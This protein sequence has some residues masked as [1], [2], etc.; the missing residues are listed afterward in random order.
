MKKLL[1]MILSAALV[2]TAAVPAYAAESESKQL[3]TVIKA[4][5]S[6]ITVA[7]DAS[8]SY[9][10]Y[11]TQNGDETTRLW[12]LTWEKDKEHV[13]VSALSDGKI[14]SYYHYKDDQEENKGLTSLSREQ[15]QK[16]AEAFLQKALPAGISVAALQLHDSRVSD[17]TTD[18]TYYLTKSGT[19]GTLL[20][21]NITF[22]VT[23]DR[24]EKAV[25][26]YYT[27][28][29]LQ[30]LTATLP[31]DS[32]LI[33]KAKAENA[34]LENDGLKLAYIPVSDYSKKQV[35]AFVGYV[36]DDDGFL[37]DAKTGEVIN[38]RQYYYR[39]YDK[40]GMGGGMA[41][42]SSNV[43]LSPAEQ[44]EVG[45]MKDLMS[46]DEAM[47]ILK[48]KVPAMSKAGKLTGSSFSSDYFAPTIYYWDISFENGS[49]IVNAETGEIQNVYYYGEQPDRKSGISYEKA[50]SIAQEFL[51]SVAPSKSENVKIVKDVQGADSTSWTVQ[52]ARFENGIEVYG[53]GIRMEIAKENG[54]V[55]NYY[56]TWGNIKEF[57]SYTDSLGKDGAF[58]IFDKNSAFAPM[59]IV[60]NTGIQ[61]Y[62]TAMEQSDRGAFL[63]YGF[64]EY[65]PFFV[66]PATGN[67]LDYRGKPYKE[68]KSSVTGYSDIAG[69]WYEATVKAL[70]DN[71][72]YLEGELFEGNKQITQEEFFR[73]LYSQYWGVQD[74][75]ELYDMLKSSGIVKDSEKAPSKVITRQ[76]AAKF[77]IRT[78]GLGKAGELQGIYK[79]AFNDKIAAEYEGYA[80]L[81]KAL[82]IMKGDSKGRFNGT[83]ALTRAEAAVILLNTLNTK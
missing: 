35:T 24:Y 14:T 23:V 62:D 30:Y 34:Y 39:A 70:L 17:Q 8:F 46:A 55:Y 51:K 49:G 73:Y 61:M 16:V 40:G 13:Y 36:R 21:K 52:L 75:D 64:Q 31:A 44:A 43:N 74:T 83:N 77:A 71:G 56:T 18:Y 81:S 54:T 19:A 29:L 60:P 57:P 5:K 9:E 28:G 33:D 41:E 10:T 48:D 53:N 72:Y 12:N 11:E 7:E 2:I 22:D 68:E 20:V 79:K 59:Y 63:A 76:E 6:V 42:S 78:L 15:S 38:Y 25:M 4:V 45:K 50:E 3:E 80:A 66:D 37:I 69:K 32:G 58:K 1:G 47:K 67:L 65:T 27:D 26:N 82:G